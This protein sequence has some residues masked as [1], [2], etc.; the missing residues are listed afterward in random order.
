MQNFHVYKSSA[1]S[2]KTYTLVREYLKIVLNDPGAVR[3]ILAITFTNAAAAEMK[4]R[5]I[6]GLG[7][8]AALGE[9]RAQ[10]EASCAGKEP[11]A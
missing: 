8:I 10:E 4:E 11:P 3:H 5:I 1:G 2:G 6:D 9:T 7:Q